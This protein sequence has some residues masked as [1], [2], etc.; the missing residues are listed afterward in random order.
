MGD[1]GRLDRSGVDAP[2]AVALIGSCIGWLP[3][4][5]A[6]LAGGLVDEHVGLDEPLPGAD[7]QHLGR[8]I[9]E[10]R[11]VHRRA[12]EPGD[13]R[14]F[15]EQRHLRLD[16]QQFGVDDLEA[17][18]LEQSLDFRLVA[19]PPATD[20][21]ARDVD[22]R[23]PFDVGGLPHAPQAGES[24]ACQRMDEVIQVDEPLG[25]IGA[26]AEQRLVEV[27]DARWIDP[28]RPD[29]RIEGARFAD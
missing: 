14:G 11:I 7:H 22:A 19:E 8:G 23:R 2:R 6:E 13:H 4:H 18:A 3:E 1:N 5:I 12:T 21:G 9:G 29:E 24:I 26:A 10:Y 20:A 15:A 17:I 27:A 28:H 25:E 16:R